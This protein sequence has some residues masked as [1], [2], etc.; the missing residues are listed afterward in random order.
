MFRIIIITVSSLWFISFNNAW[1]C[2]FWEEFIDIPD[3]SFHNL[4]Y[5]W[6]SEVVHELLPVFISKLKCRF[7]WKFI[8][9]V[10]LCS[11]SFFISFIYWSVSRGNLMAKHSFLR[12]AWILWYILYA[13]TCYVMQEINSIYIT[14]LESLQKCLT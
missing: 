14:I 7:R 10:K 4:F 8:K 12:F 2:Y 13:A 1:D 6:R 9:S 3:D 5:C 11:R